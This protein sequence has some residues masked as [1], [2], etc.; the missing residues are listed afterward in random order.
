MAVKKESAVA[1]MLPRLKT[2]DLS[3]LIR[4]AGLILPRVLDTF[5]KSL[6]KKQRSAM[7][8]V[9]P[10]G[11]GKKI[12]LQLV[13]TPTPP[14]VIGMAQPV[15][16]STMSE[17]EVKQQRIKGIRLTIDDIQLLTYQT[18]ASIVIFVDLARIWSVSADGQKLS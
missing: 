5:L 2:T 12:Y 10:V 6:D 9:M 16:I 13:G 1:A 11:G 3:P 14:I 15:K 8:K 7:D 4:M 18:K 17:K